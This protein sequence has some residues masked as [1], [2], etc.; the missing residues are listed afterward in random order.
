M[1][2]ARDQNCELRAAVRRQ[3]DDKV[4]LFYELRNNHDKAVFLFCGVEPKEAPYYVERNAHDLTIGHK[5]VAPPRGLELERPEVPLAAQV[6][7]GERLRQ[8]IE[9]G[10]PLRESAPYPHLMP[11]RE[12]RTEYEVLDAW[13]EVGYCELPDGLEAREAG[14]GFVIPGVRAEMLSI[15][16][17]GPIGRFAFDGSRR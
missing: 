3:G 16:R 13:L 2:A 7:P 6:D 9:L 17:A 4:A 14:D 11:R 10:L 5:I 1:F 15:L 12:R 8:K